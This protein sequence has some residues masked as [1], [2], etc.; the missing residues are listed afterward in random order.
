MIRGLF[1][2]L[3]LIWGIFLQLQSS[4]GPLRLP[5]SLYDGCVDLLHPLLQ[6]KNDKWFWQNWSAKE[7][8]EF[9]KGR[10]YD[11]YI[12][13]LHHKDNLTA[14]PLPAD[15]EQLLAW[16]DVY[17][18]RLGSSLAS[19]DV[20]ALRQKQLKY[21]RKWHQALEKGQGR[22]LH[23]FDGILEDMLTLL[24]APKGMIVRD[25]KKAMTRRWAHEVMLKRDL[26]S[27]LQYNGITMKK[28]W[29]NIPRHHFGRVGLNWIFNLPVLLGMPPLYLPKGK[30]FQLTDAMVDLIMNQGLTDKTLKSIDKLLDH[31]LRRKM[32]LP[33]H[34]RAKYE[35][36]RHYY[37]IGLGVY[38]SS[39]A[40]L[41]GIEDVQLAKEERKWVEDLLVQ[42]K[43][44]VQAI[45][46]LEKEGYILFNDQQLGSNRF[47]F[48]VNQC[49]DL[50]AK[51]MDATIE[52]EDQNFRSCKEMMDPQNKCPEL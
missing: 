39:V 11:A 2:W 15:V 1:F 23:S 22:G 16:I 27:L 47:C 21:L 41:E 26:R 18:E 9:D 51:R 6:K 5:A 45:Q 19:A 25:G 32:T 17:F 28:D 4:P 29:R 43:S 35:I 24:Y 14:A 49:L 42:G 40:I 31:D 38:L 10:F 34:Y 44:Q 30:P 46:S 13:Y 37:H 33:L 48:A 20:K 7:R 8:D 50:L 36:I 3:F 52:V 12:G